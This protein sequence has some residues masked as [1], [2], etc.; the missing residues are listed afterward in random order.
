[1]KLYFLTPKDAPGP[2]MLWRRDAL[3]QM[4]LPLCELENIGAKGSKAKEDKMSYSDKSR[5]ASFH[6][7]DSSF[8]SVAAGK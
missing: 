2:G 5:L 4:T 8:S 3:T 6:R 1:M 7:V